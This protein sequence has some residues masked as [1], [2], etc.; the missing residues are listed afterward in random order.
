MLICFM[1]NINGGGLK[2]FLSRVMKPH[3]LF[4]AWE[5]EKESPI[6]TGWGKEELVLLRNLCVGFMV[7]KRHQSHE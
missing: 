4:D 3:S 2:N 6:Q 1:L 5:W 7:I